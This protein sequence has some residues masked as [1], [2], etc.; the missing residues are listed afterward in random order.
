MKPIYI[1]KAGGYYHFLSSD[2]EDQF[3][4]LT[5]LQVVSKEDIMCMQYL[6]VNFIL[7]PSPAEIDMPVIHLS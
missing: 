3:K 1:Y 7:L 6:G 5:G 4:Q 2:N